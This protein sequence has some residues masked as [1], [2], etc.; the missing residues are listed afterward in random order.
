MFYF[1]S[2]EVCMFSLSTDFE[3]NAENFEEKKSPTPTIDDNQQ[4]IESKKREFSILFCFNFLLALLLLV[5]FG[6]H[7]QAHYVQSPDK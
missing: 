5:A 7:A 6:V 1:F 2:I 4:W 3:T